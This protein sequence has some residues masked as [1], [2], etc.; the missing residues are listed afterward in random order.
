MK[1]QYRERIRFLLVAFIIIFLGIVFLWKYPPVGDIS[2][3]LP[4]D[5]AIKVL[6]DYNRFN[7]SKKLFIL[8]K[9]FNDASLNK[10]NKISKELS[11]LSQ[12]EN[13]Y[14]DMD[15]DSDTKEY[16][17]K[18]WYYFSDFDSSVKS[19]EQVKQKL[20][21]L[22][23][24]MMSGDVYT[25][26][27]TDDPMGLFSQPTFIQSAN[28][29]GKL[30]VPNKGYCIIASI[31]PSVGDMEKST[32]LY[33][34][35]KSTFDKYGDSIIVYSPNFYSVENSA[36]I[37][38]DIHKITI[39]TIIILIS[40]YFFLLRTKVML[41]F[42]MT[43]LF[44]SALIAV[45]VLRVFFDDVSILVVAF[46]ASIAT[47]AEDYLFM[48][49]LNDDYKHKRFNK[50]VFWGFIATI[51]G[52][53]VLSFISFPLISQ[54]A[55][56][57]LVSLSI[58]YVIFAFIFPKLEF[59]SKENKEIQLTHNFNRYAKI[60]PILITI[61]SIILILIS[62]PRLNFDSNFRNLDYQ[63]IPL[64]EAEKMFEQSLGESR[65]PVLIYGK[66]REDLLEKSKEI[67]KL[68]PTSYTVAN[69]SLSGKDAKNRYDILKNYNFDLLNKNIEKASKEVGF[70]DGTF[71][72]SYNGIKNISTYNFD[73]KVINK[74]GFEII[75]TDRG[76]M[77][78][79]YIMP[80]DKKYIE[81]MP[82]VLVIDSKYLL[83]YSANKA[84]SSFKLFFII[85]FIGLVALIVFVV[86]KRFL[87][88][89]N[90]LF[91]P[92]ALVLSMFAMIGN[93]NLMHIFALFLMMIYGIDYG[94]YLANDKLGNSMRAVF[95]SCMT[96]FA[97]FGILS[98]SS[99]PAV[100][101][102]GYVSIVA[103]LAILILFFQKKER[104]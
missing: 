34:E 38:N 26:L 30:I 28:Q 4:N 77:T 70:R 43:T 76:Y 25:P 57:A 36:Y 64:L 60:P 93:F 87:Y 104:G 45:L 39:I 67:R 55:I 31:R 9:G 88:A 17:S 13:V 84:L 96:T 66:S 80:N 14:F 99:V 19:F 23:D 58:S 89:L 7:S 100:Y 10:A 47:I 44:V 53:F 65:M 41:L 27:N 40:V 16:F 49:F 72:N 50:Q 59:Y 90:F 102:M 91:F 73:D 97:G 46:G 6:D 71:A 86:R 32:I 78:L 94:I 98:L 37:S 33:N 15:I 75:K 12:V 8:V 92:T 95:Y 42:S 51:F 20:K 63:N 101:S 11:S 22:S 52:L 103:I 79:G 61:I 74:L 56:F 3:A 35:V 2:K 1:L 81:N 62:I 48:L 69:V 29:D 68:L 54:L 82:S 85:G 18:S 5:D 24:Q 21:N 83:S